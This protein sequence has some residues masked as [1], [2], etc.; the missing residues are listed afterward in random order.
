MK[1]V[2][3]IKDWVSSGMTVFVALFVVAFIRF[4]GT[5]IIIVTLVSFVGC[6]FHREGL[7]SLAYGIGAGMMCVGI[8]SVLA[9]TLILLCISS[10]ISC[11]EDEN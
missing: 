4:Y 9:T 5:I 11:N 2:M 10:P 3:T 1:E 6:Y 8:F 7:N